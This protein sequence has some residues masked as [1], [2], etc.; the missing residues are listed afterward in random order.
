MCDGTIVPAALGVNPFATITALA[1]RAVELVGKE[2]KIE[3]DLTTKNG[4]HET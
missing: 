1:E 2:F 3:I 4:K